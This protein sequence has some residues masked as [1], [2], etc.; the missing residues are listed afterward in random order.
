M[1]Q[2][3]GWYK[4]DLAYIHDVGFGDFALKS[5]P[6]IIEILHKNN[7]ED[8]LIVD[9][10]CGGGLSAREFIKANYQVLG[11]DISAAAIEIAKKRVPEAKFKVE[12]LFKTEI[13]PCIAVTSI[14]ECLNY[15]FDPENNL[16]TLTILFDR[17]Y[18]ALLPGGIFIFDLLQPH[19]TEKTQGFTEGEDW[20]VIYQKEEDCQQKLLTRR[21]T[22]FRKQGN[23]YQRDDETHRACLYEVAE[24][25]D[26]LSQAGFQ[27]QTQNNYG[28][29]Y[30]SPSHTVFVAQK[31]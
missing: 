20:L 27:V 9:L 8:G 6:A 29:F 18:R 22:T 5:V 28:N 1:N 31:Q 4:K 21:I 24:I 19:A 26:R 2:T 7:L 16:Q 13:P 23:Y 15:L 3:E 14:G 10:G 11:I 25:I 12:S 30:L 17:I